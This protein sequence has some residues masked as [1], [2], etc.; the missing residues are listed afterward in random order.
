M[1]VCDI[2]TQPLTKDIE[3]KKVELEIDFKAVLILPGIDQLTDY[4]NL[5][6]NNF[7]K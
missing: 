3:Y 6:Q 2:N 7:N 5:Y 1:K 4:Q